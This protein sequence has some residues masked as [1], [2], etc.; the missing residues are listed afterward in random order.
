MVT[1]TPL[2]ARGGTR[3]EREA[4]VEDLWLGLALLRLCTAAAATD[5]ATDAATGAAIYAATGAALGFARAVAPPR[6]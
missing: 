4:D 2:P 1:A 3:D 5:A 6:P